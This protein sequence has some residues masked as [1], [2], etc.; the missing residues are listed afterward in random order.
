MDGKLISDRSITGN[1]RFGSRGYKH[2]TPDGSQTI[3]LRVR[4]TMEKA[5]LIREF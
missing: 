5:D 1:K 4:S 2:I 3:R